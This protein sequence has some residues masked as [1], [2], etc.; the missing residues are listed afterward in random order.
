MCI[1]IG[2]RLEEE[3]ERLDLT[4]PE[5]VS[6]CG[7]SKRSLVDWESGKIL[8][9]TAFLSATA[10]IGVDVS[11]VLSGI[12]SSSQIDITKEEQALLDN[13]R[14]ADEEGKKAAHRV[15]DALA[16][17]TPDGKKSA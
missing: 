11:Y 17:S 3:R 7:G 12:R 4:Q 16:K 9:N 10:K 14:N 2:R 13:Y 8:P 1:E 5:L 15:L 6:L